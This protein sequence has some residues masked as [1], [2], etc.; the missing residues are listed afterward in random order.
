MNQEYG[1][2][3][4][5][6]SFESSWPTASHLYSSDF[7]HKK[8]GIKIKA[9]IKNFFWTVLKLNMVTKAH[10]SITHCTVQSFLI[11]PIMARGNVGN[12]NSQGIQRL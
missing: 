11:M 1:S 6:L 3:N 12:Y 8:I 7:V 4:S 2:F 5:D 10:I 9:Y